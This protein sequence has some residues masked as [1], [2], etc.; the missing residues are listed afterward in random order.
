MVTAFL[1]DE[2]PDGKDTLI[3]TMISVDAGMPKGLFQTTLTF[4]DGA[5]AAEHVCYGWIE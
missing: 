5:R 3:T 2:K 1:S 4:G